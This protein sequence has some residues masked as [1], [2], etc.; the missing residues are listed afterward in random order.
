MCF[1]KDFFLKD[2]AI[3]PHSTQKYGK[4]SRLAPDTA[5]AM[6]SQSDFVLL[7]GTFYLELLRLRF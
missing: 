5:A 7:I 4:K 1:E 2:A 3:L 6:S